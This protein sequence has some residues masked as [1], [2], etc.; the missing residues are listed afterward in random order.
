MIKVLF[1]CHG[2]ICRSPMGEFILKNMVA[3]N[4]LTNQFHI[5]SAA[6]SSE[7]IWNGVGNLVY[8]PARKKLLSVGLDPGDKRAVQITKADYLKYDYIL[9]MDSANVHNSLRIFGGDPKNKVKKLLEYTGSNRDVS[10]PWY[11]GN[12]DEAYDDIYEGC[13]AFFKY[14]CS[15]NS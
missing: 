1:I 5:A 3:K 2:N 13:Q 10:D 7:E 15:I 9:C 12:F 11:S 14:I 8:P 6:T 4:N